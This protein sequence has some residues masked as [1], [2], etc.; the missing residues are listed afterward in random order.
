[1]LDPWPRLLSRPVIWSDGP[2]VGTVQ[3][4]PDGP[5]ARRLSAVITASGPLT[6]ALAAAG[7]R[8]VIVDSG[9]AGP[10]TSDT[11]AAARLPGCAVVATGPGLVIYQ[12]PS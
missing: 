10:G 5:D 12:V 9:T 1:M 11:G 6:A 7:V 4:R 3:M 2:E 8:F